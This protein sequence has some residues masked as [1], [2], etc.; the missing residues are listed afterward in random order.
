M[1]MP[2]ESDNQLSAV[3]LFGNIPADALNELARSSRVRAYPQGQILCN[4]G[5]PGDNL[6]VLESGVLRIS[7]WAADGEE[8]VLA[9]MDAPAVVGEL[10][11]LDGA[12]RDATV[13]AHRAV[14]V[15]LI[16]RTMFLQLLRRE[17][18]A[19]EGL[20]A[21]LAGLVRHGNTRHADFVGLDVPGRLA[22]WLL[23]HAGV[24]EGGAVPAGASFEMRSSQGELAAELGTTRSTLNRALRGFESLGMITVDGNRV[25]LEKPEKLVT[26]T[27]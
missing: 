25:T 10:A 3:P 8:V 7:R 23:R 20:L 19:V 12:P 22:K 24:A 13:T 11:L 4:E 5:D 27:W 17:P 2:P 9:M 1:G 26:Y 15:R 18:A 6:I 14:T 21:T 16:P